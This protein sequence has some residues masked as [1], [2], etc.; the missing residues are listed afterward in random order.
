MLRLLGLEASIVGTNDARLMGLLEAAS[1]PCGCTDQSY[2]GR[3]NS[4]EKRKSNDTMA[5]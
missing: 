5:A 2:G 3:L 1:S 4:R